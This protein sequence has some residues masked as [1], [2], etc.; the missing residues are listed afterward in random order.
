MEGVIVRR[1]FKEFAG[2]LSPRE[3]AKRLN[4][5][6]IKAP[7][8]RFWNDTTIRGQRD[9]GTGILNNPIY[10]DRLEWNRTSYVKNPRTG[11]RIARV[12]PPEKRE[13]IEVPELRIVQDELWTRV[14]E[15]QQEVRNASNQP[16][17]GSRIAA[18]RRQKFLL[19]GLLICGECTGSY[20]VVAQD[21]YGCRRHRASGI[22]SNRSMIK[23]EILEKR[24][25]SG[26]KQQLLTSEMVREFVAEFR[27]EWNRLT[28]EQGDAHQKRANE[29]VSIKRRIAGIINAIEDGEWTPSLKQR[30][31]ELEQR[32]GEL[33]T[34]TITATPPPN[35]QLHPSMADLYRRKVEQLEMALN[36]PS[37]RPEATGILRSMIEH[38]ILTPEEGAPQGL[39]VEVQGDLVAILA[40]ASGKARVLKKMNPA[41]TAGST[42]FQGVAG[43]GFEPRT[44]RL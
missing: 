26:I 21:Y 16:S 7:D 20:S 25:L 22:C 11:K 40:A 4:K 39:R 27:S 31:R 29:L 24:V 5:E 41:T 35:L 33:E 18:M 14:K 15:R 10:I 17:S 43:L 30:L 32:Q 34:Q 44:F 9:R 13:I 1:I 37:I 6:K 38:I 19:S 8:C 3:I 36:D 2:G 12:N 23:R 42:A 28:R